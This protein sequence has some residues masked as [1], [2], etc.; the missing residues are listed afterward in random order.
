MEI[1][2]VGAWLQGLGLTK[3]LEAFEKN[4]IDADVLFELTADD[5]KDLG[6]EA[7]GHRRKLL[8]AIAALRR[9]QRDGQEEP[10]DEPRNRNK[11]AGAERRQLTVLFCDLV[12]STA[13]AAR[14]DPEDLRDIFGAY[15]ACVGEVVSRFGGYV[16]KYMGDGVLVYFGYPEAHED[17]PERGVRAGLAL[18]ERIGR[19][20]S[21]NEARRPSGHCYWSRCCRRL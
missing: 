4:A 17:D 16:A 19:L 10:A 9:G 2:D 15:H 21:C 7:V 6:V 5:L 11:A 14:L 20:E 3:Y 8:A 13:L 1:I 18:I 12:G